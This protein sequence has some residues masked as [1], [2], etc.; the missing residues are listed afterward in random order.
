MIMWFGS[1]GI[2]VLI[3]LIFALLLVLWRWS[4][5]PQ[6]ESG[7]FPVTTAIAPGPIVVSG[8]RCG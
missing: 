8:G 3:L 6:K 4:R 2:V 5:R 7:R 1:A